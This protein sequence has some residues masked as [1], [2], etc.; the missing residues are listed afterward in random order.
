MASSTAEK[1][2][3]KMATVKCGGRHTAVLVDEDQGETIES[4]PVQVK[5]LGGDDFSF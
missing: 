2:H 3:S 4:R 5:V 1:T